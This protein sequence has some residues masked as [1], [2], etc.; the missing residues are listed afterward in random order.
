[1]MQKKEYEKTK[2]LEAINRDDESTSEE[3][4]YNP[5][6]YCV[7]CEFNFPDDNTQ[8]Q[9]IQISQVLF[10][11]VYLVEFL[12]KSISLGLLEGESAYFR[13]NWNSLDFIILIISIIDSLSAFWHFSFIKIFQIIR[14][15]RPLRFISKNNSMKSLVSSL[16]YS[17]GG[18]LNV[19]FLL[20]FVE[21]MFAILGVSLFAGK[22]YICSN[23]TIETQAECLAAGYH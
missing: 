21:F 4:P 12:I 18:I 22:L 17:F 23:E 14:A 13:D 2:I 20:F 9:I 11:I 1:M 3:S 10:T 6:F 5:L 16:V 15:T 8:V 7:D 19:I